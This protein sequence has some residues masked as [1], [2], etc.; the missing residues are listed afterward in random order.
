MDELKKYIQ[1]HAEEL[2][3]DEPRAQVWQNIRR[4][5]QPVKKISVV[6]MITRWAAAACILALA[7]IGAWYVFGNK[8]TTHT[9]V[10]VKTENTKPQQ[11]P[12]TPIQPES[13]TI[14]NNNPKLL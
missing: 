7:G 3:L 13:V 9:E 10:I 8:N 4:E 5:T 2:D 6:V 14:E 12:S 1:N 11:T